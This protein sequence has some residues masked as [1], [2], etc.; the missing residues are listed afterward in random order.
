M[1]DDFHDQDYADPDLYDDAPAGLGD[2][3]NRLLS[4]R[5]SL[6]VVIGATVGS[7]ALLCLF[8]FLL[9]NGRGDEEP[10]P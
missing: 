8:I 6:V 3:L 4:Q 5:G 2:R 1:T 10:M 9:L 7:A